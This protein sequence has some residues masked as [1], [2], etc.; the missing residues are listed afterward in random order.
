MQAPNSDPHD[1]SPFQDPPFHDPPNQPETA[2][3]GKM[4]KKTG[5]PDIKFEVT[6]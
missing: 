6:S 3:K 5:K 1:P 4:A 2:P